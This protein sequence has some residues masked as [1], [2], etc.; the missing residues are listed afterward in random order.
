MPHDSS[1]VNNTAAFFGSERVCVSERQCCI[2]S[3]V[4]KGIF[5]QKI[6]DENLPEKKLY[7][8]IS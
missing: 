7:S 4:G 3:A 6:S 2:K 8:K 5:M 1:T